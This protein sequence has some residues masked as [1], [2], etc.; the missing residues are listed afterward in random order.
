VVW[1]IIS[2]GTGVGEGSIVAVGVG[3]NVGVRVSVGVGAAV[4]VGTAV[5]VCSGVSVNGGDDERVPQAVSKMLR[6]IAVKM[7]GL[8]LIVPLFGLVRF[9]LFYHPQTSHSF[10]LIISRCRGTN[11]IQYQPGDLNAGLNDIN[12]PSYVPR[13]PVKIPADNYHYQAI[14][15]EYRLL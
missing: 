15:P 4:S 2:S 12:L 1:A 13:K 9:P 8:V 11:K 14:F 3:V 6:N 7:A 5:S 10:S